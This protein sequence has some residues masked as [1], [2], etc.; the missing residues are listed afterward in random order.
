MVSLADRLDTQSGIF[1]LGILPTGSRDPYGLRRSVLGAC[2]ILIGM[3]VRVSLGD[4]LERAI[5]SYVDAAI[6]GTVPP[7]DAKTSLL[8]FYRGRLQHLGEADG[9]RQDSVRSALAAS[10]DDPYDARLRMAALDEIRAEPGFEVLAMA[11]KRIKNILHGR[12]VSSPD[13]ALLKEDAERA[14]DRSVRSAR[15]AIEAAQ[16]RLDHAGALREIARLG[17]PLDRFFEDVLVM[18]EDR[19][20]RDNRL[21][22]LQS[23]GALFLRV[24]DFSEIVVEGE[25]APPARA[26]RPA[27]RPTEAGR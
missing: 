8:E 21:G 13:P 24:G 7:A 18:A 1:L 14:L 6:D 23:I 3:K 27:R 22:I 2:R 26:T 4:L 15:P 25:T 17:G 10:M 11:H 16:A 20:L 5:R 12:T 9:L 19:R